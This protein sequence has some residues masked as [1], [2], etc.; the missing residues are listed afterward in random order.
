LAWRLWAVNHSRFQSFILL[1]SCLVRRE[2]L[3]YAYFHFKDISFEIAYQTSRRQRA[4]KM[5]DHS[6]LESVLNTAVCCWRA[7]TRNIHGLE[8]AIWAYPCLKRHSIRA[9][10]RLWR[11]RGSAFKSLLSRGSIRLSVG[12][13]TRVM[14]ARHFDPCEWRHLE[15]KV[16][17]AILHHRRLR[18]AQGL[19]FWWRGLTRRF[20]AL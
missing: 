14:C 5:A 12:I 16:S 7:C 10:I 2:A 15:G 11:R 4:Q 18:L 9:Y 1:L 13:A 20:G 6:H 17:M 8:A 19:V 3:R